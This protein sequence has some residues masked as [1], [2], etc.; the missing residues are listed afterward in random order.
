MEKSD[1]L[2]SKFIGFNQLHRCFY[3]ASVLLVFSFVY[4]ILCIYIKDKD[5]YFSRLV[6][7]RRWIALKSASLAGIR[8]Q[9]DG[10]D[11]IDWSKNYVICSNHT[12]NLDI[13]ALMAVCDIDFSFI[14]KE[15]LL[16]NPVT[17]L[18]F[19]T[20]D[21][22]I[23]RSSKISSF[24]AFKKAQSLLE[25]G[26][27]IA[28]FPEGGIGDTFPPQLNEFKIGA[29]KLAMDTDVPILPIIIHDA[30][31]LC[32][33]DGMAYGTTPG[34]CYITVL[35]PIEPMF[36]SNVEDLRDEVYTL[37][38]IKLSS[39]VRNISEKLDSK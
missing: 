6:K 9:I 22:P 39:I 26:K 13:T 34:K 4:P 32:W 31:K 14:G 36:F 20:I 12:S 37:F 2:K 24:R 21:I 15:A 30:W 23:N 29:F 33:D 16:D 19:K 1:S 8:F 17:S 27:S 35:K 5:K 10:Q 18:F 11:E 38:Q 25:D 28:I 3:L 7:L